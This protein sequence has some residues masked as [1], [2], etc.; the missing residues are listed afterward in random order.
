VVSANYG[1]DEKLSKDFIPEA[2]IKSNGGFIPTK[3]AATGEKE[4][5]AGRY[6][7]YREYIEDGKLPAGMKDNTRQASV[8][9]QEALNGYT[10]GKN[11]LLQKS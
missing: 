5:D 8:F 3:A 11:S 9:R 7:Q 10:Q 6:P 2:L 1:G 4:Y